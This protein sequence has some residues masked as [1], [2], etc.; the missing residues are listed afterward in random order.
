MIISNLSVPLLG[1]VDTAVLGHLKSPHFL[2]AVAV[3]S[4]ILAFLYWG[5]GFLRMGTTG[6]TAQAYGADQHDQSRLIAFR[7]IIIALCLGIMVIC[8]SPWLLEFGFTLI[9]P[10][11]EIKSI[12][13]SYSQIRIFSA[14]AVLVNYAI[15]GWL[16]GRQNTRYPLIIVLFTNSLNIGLDVL[17]VIGLDMASDGAA[18]ATL[19]AECSGCALGLLLLKQTLKRLPGQLDYQQLWQWRD[20]Q[21]LILI[22]RH[23]FIRT[24]ILLTSLAFFTS[25]GAKQGE[26]ILAA[27]VIIMNLLMFT[28]FGLDGFAHAAEA[29]VGD[30]VG[31]RNWPAFKATCLACG[32][33]SLITGV[34]FTLLYWVAGPLLIKQLTSIEEVQQQAGLYLPWLIA[35][36]IIAVWGYLLDGIFIGA[37]RT[38]AMQQTMLAAAIL[39]YLPCWY[40]SQA[41]GNHGLWLAF[42]CFNA[43]RGAFLALY[44]HHYSLQRS[45]W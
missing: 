17:L 32:L 38:A 43:A 15:I 2:A 39:V 9:G 26:V 35:L 7:S 3:G 36:P 25:Q 5:F 13:A 30:A 10:S 14:P 4:S 28:S 44:F 27:N 42:I 41:W 22:N 12:A 34:V 23:L 8:F 29:L 6:L 24:L 21:Q 45:W 18:I 16:I 33:W 19:I 37:A 1:M 11:S 20:Y 40:F 31:K